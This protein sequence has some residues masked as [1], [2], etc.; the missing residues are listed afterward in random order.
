MLKKYTPVWVWDSYWWPASVV[1]EELDPTSDVI[2]VRFENG[3]TAPVKASDI[4]LRVPRIEEPVWMPQISYSLPERSNLRA[5]SLASP[6]IYVVSHFDPAHAIPHEIVIGAEVTL[7]RCQL[8]S[9][10][11]FSWKCLPPQKIEEIAFFNSEPVDLVAHLRNAA[12]EVNK[13][14]QASRELIRRS[15]QFLDARDPQA[16]LLH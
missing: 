3:V 2:M 10:V 16:A 6:G 11:R 4:R 13:M 1:V 12:A 9:D 5:G 8:C 15:K 7:P 14:I